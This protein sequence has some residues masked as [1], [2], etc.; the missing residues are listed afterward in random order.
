MGIVA[1]IVLRPIADV[2]RLPSRAHAI[3]GQRHRSDDH[4]ASSARDGGLW[5][6]PSQARLIVQ[7]RRGLPPPRD[8]A[9]SLARP[10]E[11]G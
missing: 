6:G 1:R 5:R 11:H 10:I 8:S 7:P 9:H 4:D 2:W 3:G